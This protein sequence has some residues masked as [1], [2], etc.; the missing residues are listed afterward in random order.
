MSREETHLVEQIQI[1][2]KDANTHTA[3]LDH[4]MGMPP[5]PEDTSRPVSRK[6]RDRPET[7]NTK[8][9]YEAL[10]ALEA[11]QMQVV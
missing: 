11:L 2:G 1:I 6:T 3:I 8:K 4:A 10:A 7:P 9:A 5:P